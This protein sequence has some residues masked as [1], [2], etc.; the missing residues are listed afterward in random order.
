MKTNKKIFNGRLFAEGMRQLKWIA[1]IGTALLVLLTVLLSVNT[2]TVST[3][4]LYSSYIDDPGMLYGLGILGDSRILI[5]LVMV[6]VMMLSLFGFLNKRSASDYYHGFPVR[7]ITLYLSFGGAVL[8]WTVIVSLVSQGAAFL[9]EFLNGLLAGESVNAFSLEESVSGVRIADLLPGYGLGILQCVFGSLIVMGAMAVAMSLTGTVFTNIVTALVILLA[10]RLILDMLVGGYCNMM[11]MV[12]LNNVAGRLLDHSYNLFYS[13][14]LGRFTSPVTTALLNGR[15]YNL[16]VLSSLAVTGSG[17]VPFWVIPLVYSGLLGA[18]YMVLGGVLFVRRKSETAGAPN[19]SRRSQTLF[20]V[21]V[22]LAVTLA[23]TCGLVRLLIHTERSAGGLTGILV[24]YLLGTAAYFVYEAVAT[25]K[26]K[27][28]IKSAKVFPAVILLNLAVGVL[29]AGSANR[30]LEEVDLDTGK[31][32]AV[33]IDTGSAFSYSLEDMIPE[34]A[35]KFKNLKFTSED[36]KRITVVELF[37]EAEALRRSETAYYETISSRI[38]D[39]FGSVETV[40]VYYREGEKTKAITRYLYFGE[41]DSN[42]IADVLIGEMEQMEPVSIPLPEIIENEADMRC[43]A[44]GWDFDEKQVR[45][46]YECLREEMDGKEFPLC[47]FLGKKYNK[48]NVFDFIE[49]TC[50]DDSSEYQQYSLPISTSTPK[51]VEKLAQMGN[52]AWEDFQIS[53]FVEDVEKMEAGENKDCTY[54]RLAGILYANGGQD[55][56]KSNEFIWSTDGY[57]T[58]TVDVENLKKMEALLAAHSLEEIPS[59]DGNLLF[60]VYADDEMEKTVGHWYNLTDEEVSR[61]QPCVPFRT[62]FHRNGYNY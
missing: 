18:L 43:G 16:A 57:G 26:I 19:V 13:A 45:E 17:A 50:V 33:S 32:E 23:G 7:R 6:P 28:V 54:A 31:I 38:D 11:P 56:L 46:L 1:V 14:T 39:E 21:L 62:S 49:I 27:S 42:E 5:Y 59:M 12:P 15:P 52:E 24:L 61:L 53:D 34:A 40:T 37:Q 3:S 51:T 30:A 44:C 58:Y 41:Q 25:R 29:M 9:A 8:A 20:G 36:L 4:D 60:L 10:P 47:T 2:A 22:A 48:N 35:E 55:G